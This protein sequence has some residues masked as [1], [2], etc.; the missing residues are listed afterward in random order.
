MKIGDVVK[1]KELA[2][3]DY[4]S[5]DGKAG[6]RVEWTSMPTLPCRIGVI[7]GATYRCDGIYSPASR[8]GYYGEE[9]EPAYL[10]VTKKH[11]VWLVR[12]GLTTREVPVF[13]Q[14]IEIVDMPDFKLPYR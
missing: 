7:T 11:K 6:H 2:Y 14:G 5:E 12:F 4:I 8:G 3:K 9:Y 1:V 10:S 13:E